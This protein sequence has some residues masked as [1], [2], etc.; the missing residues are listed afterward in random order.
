MVS[1]VLAFSLL[2]FALH[3]LRVR[4]Y[5]W[6]AGAG[7]TI[8]GDTIFAAMAEPRAAP[9]IRPPH[10][11]ATD[12]AKITVTRV[13]P[14]GAAAQA[15]VTEG[16]AVAS[17]GSIEDAMLAWRDRYR[18]GPS[19]QVALTHEASGRV[20]AWTPQPVWQLPS[21]APGDWLRVHLGAIL[22]MAAF[23]AGAG[24]LVA[25]GVHGTTAMMVTLALIF[26]AIANAG[27]LL[28]SELQ[29]PL[30]GEVLLIFSWLA[31]PL[32]F[33]IIG[34]AVLH[35]PS[36]AP[37][38]DRFPWIAFALPLLPA[39]VLVVSI[40]SAAF[41]LGAD[42]ALAPLAWFAGNGWLFDASFAI[43]LGANVLIVIEGIYR[44]RTILDANE[45]R[46][47]QIVVY[48]GV[49]AV[50]AYAIKAGVPLVTELAG[51]P[52]A[53]PWMIQGGLQLVV[54]LPAVA[55]PYAVA[56]K[57]VFSPR[58]VLR[59]SLQ[60]ALAR[61]TLSV[62]MVLPVV[63]LAAA[64]ISERDRPLGDIILGQPIFY[65]MS[66]GFLALS[67]KYRDQ[68]QRALDKKFFRAEY[69]AREILVALASRVPYE[70]DPAKLVSTVMT[71]IDNALHPESIAMLAGDDGRLE[72]LTAVR[73]NVDALPRD[74]G[75]STMLQWSDE[76]L[77]V[78]LDDERSPA[79]RLPAA[80]RA[81]IAASSMS[82]L[83][84]IFA[85]AAGRADRVL[86]GVIALGQKRSEE[87]YTPED[88]KLL[89]GIA[90][91]MS[92]ALDLSR[93]RKRG[94]SGTTSSSA[95]ATPTLTPTMVARTSAPA[96]SALA[97][98]PLCHR[99][100]DFAEVRGSDGS[101]FC[102][103]DGA[104]LQPVIGMP[105]MVDGKYRVDAVVGRGGMGAVFRARDVRLQRDVAVKVVRAD[106]VGDP[107]SRARFQREAQIVAQLQHPGIVTVFDFGSLA[108]GAAFLVM[109]FVRGEDLRH[110]LK[111][112]KT[113]PHDRALELIVGI[114]TAVEAAHRAG[115]LHRDLKPENI[116]LPENGIGPKVL[117]FGVAK[118]TDTA[119]ST[120][121]VTQAAT[122]IGTPAYMAPEQLRGGVI[123]AR[124]DV[125]SLAVMT[126]ETLTG[127][128]PFGTGSF[129][130]LAMKQAEGTAAVD[131]DELPANVGLTLR[132]ALS[133]DREE[134]P[135][136]AAAF[137]GELR[138]LL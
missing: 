130:D 136:T 70:H 54:L 106:L 116:L 59:R 90:T 61:R 102:R 138:L 128:L 75:L 52:I 55:L 135:A 51:R 99:C 25:L 64:L 63:A 46:R 98:C 58:T 40:V 44:Y 117:D 115:V 104:V 32:S 53:L 73:T 132:R 21:P 72:V 45:R 123:D 108:D 124:A 110:L 3:V 107:D 77:A 4:P 60:Y 65:A 23:L 85:G 69:D 20:F 88:R 109:E 42:A 43:A 18:M 94:S 96:L 81:W 113:L 100:F 129:I 31:T 47:I 66:L 114:A 103:E 91:Q 134:R 9:R 56:V 8:S 17:P 33:P 68:A 16:M 89:S 71:Q 101:A 127:R 13:A 10:L 126:Y 67:L 74:S 7:V 120:G 125:Y 76:P 111:R 86:V 41:L 105:P 87:P 84:P 15:G 30:V 112:E 95:T 121:L 24:I 131:F 28:G 36:R 29:S 6:P 11:S 83:V 78:F 93:L 118:M 26:T 82:L 12:L 34:L 2:V 19:A 79:A 27:P 119:T 39:P 97:M 14:A 92:V 37:L 122:I 5:L 62:L 137:A 57:H 35:F 22:Q 1:V 48:T 80:D 38:L 50:F 133:L 49:S